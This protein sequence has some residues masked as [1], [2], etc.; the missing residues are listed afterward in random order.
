[1]HAAGEDRA[2]DNPEIDARSPERPRKRTEDRSEPCDVEQLDEKHL[3]RR[4]WDVVHA[5]LQT[6]RGGGHSCAAKRSVYDCPI[7]NVAHDERCECTKKCNHYLS[8]LSLP[9]Y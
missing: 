3:P 8:L 1:M 5:I 4:Q 6:D 7:Y 2:K 9:T